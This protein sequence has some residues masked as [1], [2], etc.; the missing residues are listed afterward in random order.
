MTALPLPLA[1]VVVGATL[2]DLIR[3]YAAHAELLMRLDRPC[4]Q[5]VD[6]AALDLAERRWLEVGA[7]DDDLDVWLISWPP[8]ART[9]WHDHGGAGGAMTVLDGTLTECVWTGSATVTPVRQGNTR[10]YDGRRI[11]DVVNTSGRP[12]LSLHAYSPRLSTMTHYSLIADGAG[13]SRLCV[14]GVESAGARW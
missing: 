12:A 1:G 13:E 9:G 8:D 3:E 4:A 7:D 14:A 11:H 10:T 2:E 6:A 5:V